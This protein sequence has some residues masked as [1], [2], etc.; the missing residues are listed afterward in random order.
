MRLTLLVVCVIALVT[1]GAA[2]A[3]PQRFQQDRFAIGFWVGPPIDDQL[4]AHYA[5]IAEANFTIALSGFGANT[6][7]A[8]A[9]QFALCEKHDL[10][11][12]AIPPT[13]DLAN[14]P[15][16]PTCWGY[17]LRDEP[18]AADFP[19]LRTMV[20]KVRAERPGRLAYINLFPNY[21]SEKQLGTPTYEEHVRRFVDEVDVDVLSMDH[22]PI[23]KPEKDGRDGYCETLS[24]MRE[25]SLR[26]GLPFWNFFNTMPYGP[27]TD[28]TESQLRW[29]IYT[30]LAYG[31]KGVL[32]FCYWTPQGGEFPKGGAI[33][34]AE[35]RPTRHYEQAKRINREI[36]N[37]G[38]TLMQL[39]STAVIRM[40]EENDP[41]SV[42]SGSP[43]ADIQRADVD[44]P[45]DYLIGVFSHKDGRRAVLLNNYR[46][47]FTAWPT[48]VFDAPVD[49]VR[50]VD[51]NTGQEVPVVDDSPLMEGTQLSLDA[52]AGR[53]FLL[54]AR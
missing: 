16:H 44:P 33:I 17:L 32:Y 12:L 49:L 30:S 20:D 53:L 14:L 15:D 22:Y 50:E 36:K 5:A 51:P 27:H 45:N 23:F 10:R 8:I 39:T 1:A 26:K 35:G 46:F 24:V 43:I 2:S 34:T 19:A 38:P 47:A 25:H 40:T 13:P 48:V 9:R 29:Q 6:E 42:L 11:L 3:Q 21:A 18:N 31:A 52:G 37:L 41:L 4:E 7:E 54:P 28:P